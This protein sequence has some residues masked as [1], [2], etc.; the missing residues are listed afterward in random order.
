MR[1]VRWRVCGFLICGLT[2]AVSLYAGL[3]DETLDPLLL[4]VTMTA[5]ILQFV[6]IDVAVRGVTVK[7]EDP[8][9]EGAKQ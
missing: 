8:T 3:Q 5:V 6:L 7:S 1:S 4:I 2:L 9:E